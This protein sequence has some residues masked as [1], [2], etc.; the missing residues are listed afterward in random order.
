MPVETND[1][2]EEEEELLFEELSQV[3]GTRTQWFVTFP[4]YD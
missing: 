1:P 3:Q 4:K 2:K